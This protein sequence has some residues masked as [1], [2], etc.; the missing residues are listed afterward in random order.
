MAKKK[1]KKPALVKCAT[2]GVTNYDFPNVEIPPGYEL[3]CD[4][5]RAGSPGKPRKMVRHCSMCRE[6]IIVMGVSGGVRLICKDCAKI[7][8]KL[9]Q[10]EAMV[11][12]RDKYRE[13]LNEARHVEGSARVELVA[14]K[15]EFD[16]KIVARVHEVQEENLDLKKEL[17]H[18]E[19]TS[20]T[21]RVQAKMRLKYGETEA[22]MFEGFARWLIEDRGWSAGEK[23][24][25]DD[26]VR[27]YLT[28]KDEA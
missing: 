23:I 28:V 18:R 5:C 4:K 22:Q 27:Y 19:E 2:C 11:S 15:E 3:E 7:D 24:S 8:T 26:L 21:D 20:L 25:L 17:A 12:E 9:I 6:P 14:L 16:E 13:A 10:V 1:P